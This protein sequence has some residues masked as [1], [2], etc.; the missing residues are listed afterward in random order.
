MVKIDVEGAEYSYNIIQPQLRA[1]ILEFHK[2][3]PNW[4]DKALKIKM[5]LKNAGFKCL[6]EPKFQHG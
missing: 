6:H 4:Q 2:T 5:D 3:V 1:I